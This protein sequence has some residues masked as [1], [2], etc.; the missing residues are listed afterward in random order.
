M[1]IEKLELR[2]IVSLYLKNN[3]LSV[4]Y[5]ARYLNYDKSAICKWLKGEKKLPAYLIYSIKQF[6]QGDFLQPVDNILIYED[7]K[8]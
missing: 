7:L 5:L 3:H 4:S 1:E 2:E 6:L 8:Q